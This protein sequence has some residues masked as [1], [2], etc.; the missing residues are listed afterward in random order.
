MNVPA[1]EHL[2]T[3]IQ[4]L[5]SGPHHAKE[6]CSDCDKVLR[7]LPK[8]KNVERR[9]VTAFRVAKMLP[10]P[11]LTHWEARFLSSVSRQRRFSPKQAAVLERMWQELFGD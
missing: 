5:A 2:N 10:A 9:R 1:C 8:P 6:I 4:Q 7:W 3:R 11:G